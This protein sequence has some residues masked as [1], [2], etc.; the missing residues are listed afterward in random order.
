MNYFSIG[1]GAAAIAAVIA[2]DYVNQAG[3]AGQA[4]GAFAATA[5][6]ATYRARATPAPV[7]PAPQ[8]RPEGGAP[9]SNPVAIVQPDAA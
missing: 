1:F 7:E 5:Y 4:P 2:V 9:H 8:A 3:A 6:L